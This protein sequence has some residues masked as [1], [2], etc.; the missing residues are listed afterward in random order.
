MDFHALHIGITHNDGI[1]AIQKVLP[2]CDLTERIMQLTKFILEHNFFFFQDNIY[3]Q[4]KGTAMGTK[5]APQYANIFLT[6]LEN[7]FLQ[8]CQYKPTLYLRYIDDIF[9][10][11]PHGANNLKEFH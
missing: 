10:I 9:M 11:W 7:K 2:Q 4:V 6:D 5:M 1:N 8:D 3:L